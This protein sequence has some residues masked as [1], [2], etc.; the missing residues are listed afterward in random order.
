MGLFQRDPVPRHHGLIERQS[1]FRAIPFDE[2]TNGVIVGTLGTQRR[3]AVQNR[4]FDCSRSGSFK[5]VFGVRFDLVFTMSAVWTM[6]TDYD[7]PGAFLGSNPLKIS[8]TVTD[9]CGG[10]MSPIAIVFS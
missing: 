5:T 1:R 9:E 6:T 2:F 8:K 7:D 4:C 10:L 3:E